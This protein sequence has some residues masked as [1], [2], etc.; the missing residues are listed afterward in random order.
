[1]FSPRRRS[2]LLITLSAAT[3]ALLCARGA[4]AQTQFQFEP[5]NSGFATEIRVWTSGGNAFA[6]VRLTLPD[7]GYRVSDWGQVIVS[8]NQMVVDAK[9]ER[10]LCGSAQVIII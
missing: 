3:L 6:Q 2:L 7:S 9:V 8:G 1:M 5:A 10:C 4:G